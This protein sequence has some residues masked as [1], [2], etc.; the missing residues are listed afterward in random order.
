MSV[1][2]IM[3]NFNVFLLQQSCHQILI[4]ALCEYAAM[5]GNTTLA[6]SHQLKDSRA[7]QGHVAPLLLSVG[8]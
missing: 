3:G 2:N 6:F 8:R 1:P 7:V 4:I 5:R